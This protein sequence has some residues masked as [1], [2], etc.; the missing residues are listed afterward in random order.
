MI[1]YCLCLSGCFISGFVFG[2][3]FTKAKMRDE[4]DLL[5]RSLSYWQKHL[6]KS[7]RRFDPNLYD[8]GNEINPDVRVK[9]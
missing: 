9:I 8:A 6:G 5:R 1:L 7:Y 3:I 4:L 2:V